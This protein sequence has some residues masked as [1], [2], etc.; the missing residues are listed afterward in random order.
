MYTFKRAVHFGSVT[1][2]ASRPRDLFSRVCE[3]ALAAEG[4]GFDAV[5]APDH[6]HQGRIGGGADKPV[7]EVWTLLGALGARTRSVRLGALVSPVTTR[8]P[9]LVAKSVTSLD[10]ITGGRAI[11]GYG[12]GWDA[13]EHAAYGIDFPPVAERMARLD[14]ALEIAKL[15]LRGGSRRFSGRY[16][17]VT[18]PFNVPAALGTVPIIVGGG[19]EK[20][21]LR[22]VAKHADACN[23]SGDR[24]GLVRKFAVLEEHCKAVGRDPTEVQKTVAIPIQE[25]SAD[26]LARAAEEALSAGAQGV[27]FLAP[28]EVSTVETLGKRLVDIF[29]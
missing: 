20:E 14:E 21:T 11:L 29:P 12:A 6:L 13:A 5:L 1:D 4:S 3:L 22:L 7:F 27:V 19:G 23:V 15:L 16:F 2:L 9:A 18:D 28:N 24:D 10:A 26:V 25:G 17:S 8:N